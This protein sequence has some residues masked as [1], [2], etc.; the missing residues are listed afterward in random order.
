MN[1]T[2]ID[3]LKMLLKLNRFHKLFLIRVASQF[4]DGFFQIGLAFIFI[5][6][7]SSTT[8]VEDIASVMSLMLLP[9]TLLGPFAGVFLD[10]L[11]RRQ[12]LLYGN[13]FRGIT[14]LAL[15]VL[16]FTSAPV[17]LIWIF[18]LLAL[19]IN[20]FVLSGFSASLPRVLDKEYLLTA[21]AI[22]PTCGTIAFSIGGL[23]AG[24]LNLTFAKMQLEPH[25]T[26]ALFLLMAMLV[27]FIAS[28]LARRFE[29]D[30]LGPDSQEL[31]KINNAKSEFFAILKELGKAVKH[32][33]DIGE[34]A[35]G[36]AVIFVTRFCYGLLF[37]SAILLSRNYLATSA[38]TFAGLG[39]LSLVGIFTAIG[40]G[41]A[42]V[43]T[44]TLVRFIGY[45]GWII[46]SLVVGGIAEAVLCVKIDSI[47]IAVVSLI[48]SIGS[49]SIKISVD[50]IVQREVNDA[51]RGRAFALYD[52]LNNA[53]FIISAIFAI[54]IL[55]DSGHSIPVFAGI[56]VI[57]LLAAV[58]V[59]QVYKR[60]L[61]T[62]PT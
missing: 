26:D 20:R 34:P 48:L 59:H 41:V 61:N 33:I 50:T 51:Y 28:M 4:G 16:L 54:A 8:S 6:A 46:C 21:N 53:A 29:V 1:N 62:N 38:S 42:V 27:F 10:K 17:V 37:I 3:D 43:I 40:F 52:V 39:T 2:V 22:T 7:P 5:F 9:F 12:I 58:A 23:I 18:G 11:K 35:L 57:Y 56:S 25:A 60:I 45:Q 19:T 31:W 55:P 13:L 32:L 47:I 15:A 36:L 44:P 49:Q 30:E 24:L 14:C